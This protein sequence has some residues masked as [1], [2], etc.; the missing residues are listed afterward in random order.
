MSFLK[1]EN[2]ASSFENLENQNL[3]LFVAEIN[4]KVS[5]SHLSLEVSS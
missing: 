3:K 2:L 1:N 4:R 5:E